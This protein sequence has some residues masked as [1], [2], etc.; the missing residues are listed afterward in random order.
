MD[1]L[2]A[3]E[4][5][6]G[7]YYDQFGNIHQ[8]TWSIIKDLESAPKD[9]IWCKPILITEKWIERFGFEFYDYQP[10][11]DDDFIYKDYKI[12]KIGKNSFYSCCDCGLNGWEFCLKLSWADQI[13]LS[14]IKYVHQL[15]NLYFA[16][17]QTE[18]TFTDQ[19]EQ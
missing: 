16:L 15:Q 17:T 6:I 14:K 18:L 19:P 10:N 2:I 3:N 5:R 8:V 13:S 9:Q 7:N 1:Q 4:L 12:D 11:P